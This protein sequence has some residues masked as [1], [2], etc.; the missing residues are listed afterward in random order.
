LQSIA[1]QKAVSQSGH[2]PDE[3]SLDFAELFQAYYARIYNYLRH[4]V[5]SPADAEDLIG[6]IFERAYTRREQFDPAKGSFA[7]WLFRIAHNSLVSHYRAAGHRSAW[8]SEAGLPADLVATEPSPEAVVVQQELIA[9]VLRSLEQLNERDR[10]IISLKFA[11]KLRNTEI[12][13]I[14]NMKE[15]TVSVVLLRAVERLRQAMTGEVG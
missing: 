2:P 15:K 5:N 9:Q 14:M 10:E 4:R 1:I 3:S 12:A 6:A 8:E 7:T 13:E 11:G